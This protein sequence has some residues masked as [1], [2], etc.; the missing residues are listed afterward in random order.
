MS[1]TRLCAVVRPSHESNKT[2]AKVKN[3]AGPELITFSFRPRTVGKRST[4]DL[5]VLYFGFGF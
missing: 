1:E 4:I 5:R 3:T 2:P